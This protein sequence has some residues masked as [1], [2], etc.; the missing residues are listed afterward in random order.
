[1]SKGSLFVGWGAPIPGR[2]SVAP[3]VLDYAVQYLRSLEQ[4]G[5]VDAVKVAA[6]EPPGGPIGGFVVVKGERETLSK[7]RVDDDFV[8]MLVGV[9]LVHGHVAVAAAWRPAE[10]D[11]VLR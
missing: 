8:S 5:T 2:E 3:L 11:A 1:M 10:L 4:G 6:V 9:Q 7:L